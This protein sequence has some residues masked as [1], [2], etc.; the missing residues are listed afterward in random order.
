MRRIDLVIVHCD[1][2]DNPDQQS[3]VA[4]KA[5]HKAATDVPFKWGKYDTFGKGFIDVG[6]QYYIDRKGLVATGR[7]EG[8]IGAHCEGHNANSIGI[9]LAGSGDLGFTP[10]Q[11][12]SL[13][14]L[15]LDIL[16]R[17]K[18]TALDVL[19]HRAFNKNKTCPNF[20]LEGFLKNI[21]S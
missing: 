17:H 18:L 19:P 5:F 4:L 7:P 12:I 14:K 21:Y 6:Y 8:M 11:F 16:D 15:L 10:E 1:A 20:D 3:M 13:K 2:T 9:C